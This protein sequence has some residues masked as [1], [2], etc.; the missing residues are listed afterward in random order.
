MKK[1]SSLFFVLV[2]CLYFWHYIFTYTDWHFIDGVNLIFHE[3]GHTIFSF[4]GQFINILMGSGFQ[5]LL[6]LCIVVYFFITQQK[7]SGSLTLLW[8][9][10]NIMNVS[11]YVGDSIR[12]QLPLL[13][14]DNVIHDWNYLLSTLHILKYTD[15]IAKVLYMSGIMIVTLGTILALYYV[16]AVQEDL[17]QKNY[18]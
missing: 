16:F 4:F 6:P 1:Y 9:G 8:V 7:I 10:Q 13:G 3:A 5:T 11:V 2:V 17:S 14:G 12:M 18:S 15:T